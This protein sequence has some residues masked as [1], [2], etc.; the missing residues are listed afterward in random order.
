MYIRAKLYWYSVIV[1][2]GEKKIMKGIG[3]SVVKNNIKGKHYKAAIGIDVDKP[4]P[5]SVN[6]LQGH[7]K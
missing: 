3:K 4:K 1:K 2:K 6:M 5:H 7:S